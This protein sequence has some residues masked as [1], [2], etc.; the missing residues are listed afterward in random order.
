MHLSQLQEKI[1][2]WHR[3]Q[4]PDATTVEIQ[5]KIN[6]EILELINAPTKEAVTQELADVLIAIMAMCA[7]ESIDLESAILKKH[8]INLTRNWYRDERGNWMRDK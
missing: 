5:T 7:K 6:E 4:F 1:G 3:Y 8:K 2:K